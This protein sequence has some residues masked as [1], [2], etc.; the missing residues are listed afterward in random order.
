MLLR[1]KKPCEYVKDKVNKLAMNSEA[2]DCRK[3]KVFWVLGGFFL[4]CMALL[5]IVGLTKFVSGF[6]L[7][8]YVFM[9][10]FDK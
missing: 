7:S 8:S 1:V 4:A 10:R 9:H 6:T 2:S 5:N 3:E